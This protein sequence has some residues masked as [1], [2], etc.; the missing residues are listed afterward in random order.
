MS[1][2]ICGTRTGL[3]GFSFDYDKKQKEEK[4]YSGILMIPRE[5]VPDEF[6]EEEFLA[7]IKD[8]YCCA[9]EVRFID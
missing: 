5:L 1:C 7:E 8:S 9:P 4:C 3:H 6:D 2:N